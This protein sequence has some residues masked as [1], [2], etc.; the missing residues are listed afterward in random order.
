MKDVIAEFVKRRKIMLFNQHVIDS[1]NVMCDE[2]I[3]NLPLDSPHDDY[4]YY[5][6]QD[7]INKEKSEVA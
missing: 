6:F 3:K 1:L 2:R 5:S 7:L 4:I